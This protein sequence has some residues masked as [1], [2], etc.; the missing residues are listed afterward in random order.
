MDLTPPPV[1]RRSR[2]GT[3]AGPVQ[4]SGFTGRAGSAADEC[5]F[6]IPNSVRVPDRSWP[7][8]EI[9]AAVSFMCNEAWT[10]ADRVPDSQREETIMTI[11]RRIGFDGA[12]TGGRKVAAL[13]PGLVLVCATLSLAV[14][15]SA[16]IVLAQG[17][18]PP[19]S[20][21]PAAPPGPVQ[22]PRGPIKALDVVILSTM[23][24]D[25]AGVG[26]WGFSALIETE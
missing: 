16:R 3:A 14:G 15:R 22:G 17:T 21:V 8:L 10:P 4:R 25:R 11:C 24:A 5:R 26:E 23:L 13:V 19:D 18:K 1:G 2:V 6:R 12:R 9:L 20:A 7:G